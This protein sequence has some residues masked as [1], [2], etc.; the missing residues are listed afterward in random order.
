MD[1]ETVQFMQTAR[2]FLDEIHQDMED[3]S[4]ELTELG[5][6]VEEFLGVPIAS[7]DPISE[8]FPP[9]QVVDLDLAVE[10]L[11]QVHGGR[12]YGVAGPNRAHI[13]SM[14]DLLIRQHS[15]FKLGPVSYTRMAT[16][17]A[18]E[19]RVV[20]YG[21]ALLRVGEVPVALLQRGRMPE[22][23]REAYTLEVLAAAPEVG[24][25]FLGEVR[26]TMRTLSVI[27]GQVISFQRDDF[28]YRAAGGLLTFLPRPE[29]EAG[30][31]ILPDGVLERV[32]RHVI[33]I[34][35][36]RDRLIAAEQ[37]L[38]RGVLLYGPPGTGKTHLVRHLLSQTPGTT[39]VLLSGRTLGALS[40]ATKLARAAQPAIVVLEDC[41][42]VAEERGGDSNA[43]LFETLEA[44]DG[45]DGDADIT[46]ILTTNRPDLLERALVERPGRVDLAVEIGKPDTYARERLFALYGANL[47]ES[48]NLSQS[49][50]ETAA[51]RTEGVT[52]SFAKEAVR[53]C[54][55]QAA[56]EDRPPADEDLLRALTE[57][58][59]DG[60][61]LTRTLL[62]GA[63]TTGAMPWPDRPTGPEDHEE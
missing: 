16:G 5:R 12:Q 45:L 14:T 37:H 41:D 50:I 28:N 59:S 4:N 32:S 36:Q 47:L 30:Q 61:L 57:M 44:M 38:K 62:G 21:L 42:L 8:E 52:A 49:T 6:H 53:R 10:K 2:R 29:L 13:Q 39:A 22:Y 54:I 56:R 26:A 9:H 60:E 17:P 25:M 23:G 31:V 7:A 15:S 51:A 27:R 43:A 40:E 18:S 20:S 58:L 48:G 46:F 24:D 34:G 19:R 1:A 63:P 55:L 33:G 11:L 35:E 3:G